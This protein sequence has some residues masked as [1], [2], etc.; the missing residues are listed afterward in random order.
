[1]GSWALVCAIL[2]IW[3]PALPQGDQHGPGV[4]ERQLLSMLV[5]NGAEIRV[6]IATSKHGLRSLVAKTD[7]KLGGV[8][9][10]V[11]A[12]TAIILGTVG[13][14]APVREACHLGG[15][16]H[17]APCHASCMDSLGQMRDVCALPLLCTQGTFP[18]HSQAPLTCTCFPMSAPHLQEM[19]VALLREKYRKRPRYGEHL[20]VLPPPGS[21]LCAESLPPRLIPMLASPELESLV[22]TKQDWLH[23]VW[24]GTA[25]DLRMPLARALPEGVNVTLE[26][27]AWATCVVGALQTAFK[28]SWRSSRCFHRVD[29]GSLH[30]GAQGAQ[31]AA[32]LPAVA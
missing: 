12:H 20:A 2:L 22:A 14:T 24:N 31:D 4:A 3:A 16:G 15:R 28:Q 27:L 11:P 23:A 5:E 29:M 1:M 13:S 6:E 10:A 17:T 18:Q 32:V 21:Q 9:A 25:K 7:V 19:A 26:E 30:G 8:L